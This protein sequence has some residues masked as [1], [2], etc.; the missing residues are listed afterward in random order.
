MRTALRRALGAT[1]PPEKITQEPFEHKDK[2]LRRLSG[3]QAGERP[4][5]NDLFDYMEDLRYTEIQTSLFVYLLPICLEVWRNDVCRVDTSYAGVVEHFYPVLADRHV[6][7]IHLTPKQ[8]AVVSDFM[9][10]AILEE[11]DQQRG[12]AFQGS[13]TRPYR[14]VREVTTYGV[15]LPDIE[16]LWAEWWSLGT[17]GRAVAAI[18]YI[19][20][21]MYPDKEN[22]VFAPWTPDGGGGPPCLW[23]FEGH[24]YTHRWLEP[25][26][27]FLRK[28]LSAQSLGDA[29]FRAVNQLVGEPEYS[30]ATLVQE[31]FPLCEAT[32]AARCADLPQLLATNQET[33]SIFEWP[34]KAGE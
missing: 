3:L 13:R 2:H 8:T 1:R 31:D 20:C 4:R 24:L 12:L 26:V 34:T 23:E 27:A 16:R 33:S 9:K 7:D 21:L 18:Q 28:A 30:V 32:V 19:S 15:I 22:P 11:I 5:G 6:F 29:L 14:W 25:N 10:K 17:I